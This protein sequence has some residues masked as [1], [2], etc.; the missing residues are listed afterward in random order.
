MKVKDAGG[1]NGAV[2]NRRQEQ[3]AVSAQTGSQISLHE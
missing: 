2:Y 3:Q 1:M